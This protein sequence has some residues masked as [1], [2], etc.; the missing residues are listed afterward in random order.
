MEAQSLQPPAFPRSGSN[1]VPLPRGK[2][3]GRV[4]AHAVQTIN[5]SPEQV[6]QVYTRP[7]LLPA[8]QEGVLSVTPTGDNT[9]HWVMEEPGSGKQIEFDSEILEAVPGVRHVSRITSGP[10]ESTTDTITFETNGYGRGTVATLVG[11]FK[12]PGGA[13]ANAIATA[14][15]RGPEQLTIE[16]LRHLKQLIE[17]TEIPSVEGQPAGPRGVVG[18]WKQLLMGENLP[19]PPGSS[20]RARPRDLAEAAADHESNAMVLGGVAAL[21]ALAAWYGIRRLR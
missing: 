8:W 7:E 20:D 13:I 4:V 16:N 19:T 14:A 2:G 9:L 15:S 17:S 11:D 18:K 1:Y 3:N 12:V 10:F 5:A 21:V 6:Y